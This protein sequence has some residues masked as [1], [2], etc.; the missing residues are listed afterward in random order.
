M[1]YATS[2]SSRYPIVLT[3]LGGPRSIPNPH[4]KFM[5]VQGIEPATSWSVLRYADH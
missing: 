5:E 2:Q 1:R 4:F 3:R